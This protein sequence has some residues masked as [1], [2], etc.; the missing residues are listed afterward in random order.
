MARWWAR[1]VGKGGDCAV[2]KDGDNIGQCGGA[3]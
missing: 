2:G 1:H 3:W